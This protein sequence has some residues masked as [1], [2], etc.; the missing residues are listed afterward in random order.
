MAFYIS[1]FFTISQAKESENPRINELAGSIEALSLYLRGDIDI[2]GS[3]EWRRELANNGMEALK[4][5]YGFLAWGLADLLLIRSNWD[6]LLEDLH[7]CIT[8]G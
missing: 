1:D 6:L 5:S 3:L 4:K 8:S 7:Q 2:G